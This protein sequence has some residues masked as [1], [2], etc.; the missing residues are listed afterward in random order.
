MKRTMLAT[1]LSIL[2]LGLAAAAVGAP[3]DTPD[4]VTGT[5]QCTSHGGQNGDMPFTLSLQQDGETVTGSVSSPMGGA[6]ITKATFKDDQ[7]EIHIDTDEANYLLTA[8]LQDGML[9]GNWSTAD[10][11]GSWEGKKGERPKDSE[12]SE[13]Q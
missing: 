2:V 1:G 4:S 7:L 11:K 6:D 12:G 3:G 9:K 5:W 13:T 10:E 8:T